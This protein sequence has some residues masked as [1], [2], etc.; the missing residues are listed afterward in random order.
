MP[1]LMVLAAAILMF[2]LGIAANPVSAHASLERSDPTPNARLGSTPEAFHLWFTEPLEAQFSS[3]HL[4][5]SSGTR[6][7]AESVVLSADGRQMTLRTGL[8]PDGVYTIV[9]R[10]VSAAD[11]HL[12]QGSYPITIGVSTISPLGATTQSLTLDSSVPVES[13]ALRWLNLLGLALLAGLPI[14]ALSAPFTPQVERRCWTVTWG[15]WLLAG[16]TAF[17]VLAAQ[18]ALISGGLLPDALT[19]MVFETRYGALWLARLVL[20]TLYGLALLILWRPGATSRTAQQRIQIALI[21]LAAGVLLTQSLYSHGSGAETNASLFIAADW[22]H[23]LAMSTWV[24]GLVGLAA[25]TALMR[26]EPLLAGQMVGRFSN[27]ARMAVLLLILSGIPGALLHIG[28][29]EALTTTVYGAALIIKLVLLAPL[30][31][32]AAVNLLVTRRRLREGEGVWVGRLRAL[33]GVEVALLLVILAAAGVMTAIA[34]ARQVLAERLAAPPPPD[35]SIFE[36]E[37]AGSVMVHMLVSPGLV[38][39]NT[40][41]VELYDDTTGE[42]IADAMLIRLRL[43]HAVEPLGE[44]E[45]R[46]VHAEDGRYTVVGSNLSIPGEWRIRVSIQRPG[47]FDTVVDFT[48]LIQS[49]AP[50]P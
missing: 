33:V 26:G 50:V 17:L 4:V 21:L 36:M 28:S 15:G 35:T 22:L 46:P 6:V 32:V 41:T 27:L 23:L 19:S 10:V 49:E 7:T 11:G 39:E 1:R 44:S 16:V 38:G 24:G 2:L 30:L 8:L 25:T 18:T 3:V 13:A 47:Q 45:L 48:P 37:V 12:T 31:G 42:P 14:F 29:F 40:F 20:W 43:E 9:W 34:P 5:D